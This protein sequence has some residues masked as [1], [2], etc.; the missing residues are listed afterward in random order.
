M[1]LTRIPSATYRLQLNKDFRFSDASKILDYLNELGREQIE[2]CYATTK[3][4]QAG[5]RVF[6]YLT[7][8]ERKL[9]TPTD[10]LLMSVTAFADEMERR[11]SGRGLYQTPMAA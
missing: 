6:F 8:A 4:V 3:I 7:D 9:D 1:P 11:R 10:K 2:T 5:I